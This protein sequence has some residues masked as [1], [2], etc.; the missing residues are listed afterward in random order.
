MHFK[1]TDKY[2]HSEIILEK[3][4]EM[5]QKYSGS[6][7]E[8][9]KCQKLNNLSALYMIEEFFVAALELK[10]LDW[11]KVFLDIVSAK[12]PQSVKEMRMLG[13]FHEASQDSD[14]AKEIYN[15]LISINPTDFQTIKRLIALHRD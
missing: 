5:C 4:I 9:S 13:Q 15:E 12:H 14:K 11:A 10:K 3:G 6:I 8:S 2:S 7:D 1:L